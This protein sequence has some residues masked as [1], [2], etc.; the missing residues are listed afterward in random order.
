MEENKNPD[1]RLYVYESGTLRK[2]GSGKTGIRP[3]IFKTFE[4][5]SMQ[6]Y[7]LRERYRTYVNSQ[8][9]IIEYTGP[10]QSRIRAVV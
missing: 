7:I 6:I 10:F 5:C 4:E 1:F 3:H 8:F 9:V 2:V